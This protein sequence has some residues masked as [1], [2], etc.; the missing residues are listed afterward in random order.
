MPASADRSPQQGAPGERRAH[1]RHSCSQPAFFQP[2]PQPGDDLWWQAEICDMSI[3]GLALITRRRFEP[4]T[5]LDV[6]VPNEEGS[7]ER[8]LLARVARVVRQEDATW[9]IGCEFLRRID[10]EDLQALLQAGSQPSAA[11]EST[12]A[13]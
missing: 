6:Q 11:A 13:H 2:A 1:V 12:D 10:N 3:G 8:I 5:I 9:L 4:G 7:G